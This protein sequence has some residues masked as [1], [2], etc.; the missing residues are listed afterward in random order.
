MV[1]F[2][3]I[4]NKEEIQEGQCKIVN[5]E[6]KQIALFNVKGE[7]CAIDN[8][9]AHMGGPLGEG[10]LEEDIVTCPLHGWKY[11]VKDGIGPE[12]PNAKVQKYEIKVEDNKV[13]IGKE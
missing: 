1:E 3:E 5:V 7:I 9:C 10:T 13:M 6:D 8:K 2:V 11:N 4:C 12:N